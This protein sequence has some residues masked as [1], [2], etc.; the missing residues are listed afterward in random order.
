MSS[1]EKN[2]KLKARPD[3]VISVYESEYNDEF[4]VEVVYAD[5]QKVDMENLL[6]VN[7]KIK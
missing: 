2:L 6:F 3:L 5:S 1:T 7:Q 4:S